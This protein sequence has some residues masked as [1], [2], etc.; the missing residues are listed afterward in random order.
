MLEKPCRDYEEKLQSYD[1]GFYTDDRWTYKDGKY[2]RRES[3]DC[4][5]IEW[6]YGSEHKEE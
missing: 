1:G 6:F 3:E 5:E 2:V 4:I